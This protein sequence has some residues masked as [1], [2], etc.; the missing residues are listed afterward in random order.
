MSIMS[1]AIRRYNLSLDDL[2]P[3]YRDFALLED[4]TQI[5]PEIRITVFMPVDSRDRGEGK[6]NILD[7]PE[8][9]QEVAQLPAENFEFSVHGYY[10]HH[11]D[12]AG[13]PEFKHLTQSGAIEL[14]LKCEEAFGKAGIRCTKG[15]RPPRWEMSRGTAQALEELDYLYLSDNPEFYEAHRGI[16]IPR[17]FPNSDIRENEEYHL[18]KPFKRLLLDSRRYYLHRGHLVSLCRNNLTQDT[19]DNIVR[20]VRSF[21]KVEFKFLSEIAEEVKEKQ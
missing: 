10:H 6:N 20:T 21:E 8:W 7:H 19:F 17:L 11:D 16:E 5:L 4:L 1:G 14:L 12:A 18:V 3:C 2:L 9:C 15:F 13:T